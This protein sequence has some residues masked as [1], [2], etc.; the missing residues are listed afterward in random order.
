[1][2]NTATVVIFDDEAPAGADNL[3]FFR[4]SYW[5]LDVNGNRLVDD[6]KVTFYTG[7]AGL[8][9][10]VGDWDGDGFDQVGLFKDGR[11]KLDTNAN[12]VYDAYVDLAFTYGKKGDLPV[13]G[14]WDGDG[15]DDVGVYRP[16][17]GKWYLNDNDEVFS[18]TTETALNGRQFVYTAPHGKPVV[19][20]WDGD[21]AD[22][23][24]LYRTDTGKFKRD[25][26]GN[27][28]AAGDAWVRFDGATGGKPVAGDWDGDGLDEVGV[29]RN[30]TWKLDSNGDG[31]FGG[32]DQVF[33]YSQATG[34]Q[35]VTGKW[36]APSPLASSARVSQAVK[37]KSRPA[38]ARFDPF[39]AWASDKAWGA[40]HLGWLSKPC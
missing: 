26:D 31:V 4:T 22:D 10:V 19:G 38:D 25:L 40:D 21:G 3:G 24:G 27:H 5:K 17:S 9:P 20:D 29:Y 12:G 13:V 28:L 30:G 39:G 7:E 18:I 37:E 34:T 16:A 36:P 32:L 6:P 8:K 23:V 1:M 2:N 11:W 15:D 35:P 33:S 14:D